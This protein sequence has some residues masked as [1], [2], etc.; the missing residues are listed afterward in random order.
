[1]SESRT[2]SLAKAIIWRVIS[3]GI[4]TTVAL[5]VGSDSD[6][7]LKIGAVD[8]GVKLVMYYGFE[9]A[10]ARVPWGYVDPEPEASDEPSSSSAPGSL[11]PSTA[12]SVA[13]APPPSAA[14]P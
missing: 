13:G 7:A 1:M 5:A 10:M 9:R 3:F 11:A 6:T 4:T 8:F 14:S 12:G 2:R